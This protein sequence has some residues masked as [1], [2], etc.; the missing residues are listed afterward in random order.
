MKT[1]AK[2]RLER[3]AELCPETAEIVARIQ[4]DKADGF[5]PEPRRTFKEC[6]SWPEAWAFVFHRACLS[7]RDF[8]RWEGNKIV[9][10]VWPDPEFDDQIVDVLGKIAE[11]IGRNN[12][13]T[14]MRLIGTKITPQGVVQLKSIFPKAS[15]NSYSREEAERNDTLKYV[16]TRVKWIA[17]LHANNRP[18]PQ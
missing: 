13:L 5:I 12:D 18:T 3:L 8:L 17:E 2:S 6:L 4:A 10:V 15:I 11:R 7:Y 14:E 9:C 1:K 16:N